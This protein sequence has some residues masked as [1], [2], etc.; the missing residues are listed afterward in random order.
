MFMQVVNSMKSTSSNQSQEP[1]AVIGLACRLPGGLN[2]PEAFWSLLASGRMAIREV[3]QTTR[4]WSWPDAAEVP[5]YAALLDQVDQFDAPFFHI[6]PKEATALDPQQRLLLET[7]WEA[8]EQAGIN[9]ASLRGSDTG[10]FVGIF[11][12]DYQLLQIKQNAAPHLYGSTGTSAATASGRLSYFLGLQG[13]AVSIDT[14]SS[15]SL[16]AFHLACQSLWNGECQMA[17]AS[18][19]NLILAEWPQHGLRRRGKW[20]CTGRG[21]WRCRLE[22]TVCGATRRRQCPGGCPWHSDQ[23]G[24]SQSGLDGS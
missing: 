12:N 5:P 6:S 23:P 20:L 3:S 24:W 13:P 7:S 8:L 21:L 11:L 9:P 15:S 19:V 17:L 22:A 16:V 4:H 18:G 1:L 2:T 10:I 14:A